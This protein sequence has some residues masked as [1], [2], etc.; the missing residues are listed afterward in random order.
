MIPV[1]PAHALRLDSE[2]RSIDIVSL[3]IPG[4]EIGARAGPES[5]DAGLRLDVIDQCV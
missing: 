4:S 1:T 3:I 2:H 5:D